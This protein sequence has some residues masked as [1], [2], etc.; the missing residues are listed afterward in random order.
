MKGWIYF[1]MDGTLN[2]FFEVPDWLPKLRAFD[3]SPYAE[4]KVMLNMS[5]LA[6]YLNQLQKLGW[7]IGIIS[8]RSKVSNDTYDRQ[9]DGAKHD[10]LNFHL[11]SVKFDATHII[12]YGIAKENYKESDDDILFDDSDPIRVGWGNNA[13]PPEQILSVLKALIDEG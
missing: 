8:W 1:D 9:V 6:R 5:L 4:A 2:K 12:P 3:P 11:R 10:W 7:K 13:Y